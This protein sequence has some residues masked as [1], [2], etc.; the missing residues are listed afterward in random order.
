MEN[1]KLIALIAIYKA[2]AYQ[3]ALC[4]EQNKILAENK[5]LWDK[6]KQTITDSTLIKSVKDKLANDL[7]NIVSINSLVVNND[8]LPPGIQYN[9]MQEVLSGVN[10]LFIN[11]EANIIKIA[12]GVLPND[13]NNNIGDN[14]PI[15]RSQGYYGTSKTTFSSCAIWYI[16]FALNNSS[17][18]KLAYAEEFKEATERRTA[19]DDD[20]REDS[21][22]GA[23]N[24]LPA[25]V[26]FRKRTNIN[27]ID[28]FNSAITHVIAIPSS[29]VIPPNYSWHYIKNGIN[30]FGFVHSGY[31]FGG[32]LDE[33]SLYPKG[34]TFEPQD[35]SSFVDLV[36]SVPVALDTSDELCIYR[37]YM[38]GF[39]PQPWK[40]SKQASLIPLYR[41]VQ[42][43]DVQIGDIYFFREFNSDHLPATS[44][45]VSGHT[46][47]VIDKTKEQVITVGDDRDMPTLEGIG[48]ANFHFTGDSNRQ[49]FFLRLSEEYID[50]LPD[51]NNFKNLNYNGVQ[52]LAQIIKYFDQLISK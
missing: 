27:A 15:L 18:S 10:Q 43:A 46:T 52:D 23:T 4:N 3:H 33:E 1:N 31:S 30:G 36:T 25:E 19:A 6:Q 41:P 12:N 9:K 39:I 11:D 7:E 28:I 5:I 51:P 26:E 8:N 22:T 20:V 34:K 49:V 13:Y 21:S 17:L 37:S 29:V 35:C 50:H 48:I 45:G 14:L 44:V 2:R 24:K 40:D 32:S 16:Y 47:I 42:P 38:G